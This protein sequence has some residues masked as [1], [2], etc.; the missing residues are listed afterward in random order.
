MGKRSELWGMTVDVSSEP[1]AEPEAAIVIRNKR[2]FLLQT[3]DEFLKQNDP[4]FE[5]SLTPIYFLQINALHT[6]KP[7]I[8]LLPFRF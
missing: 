2:R 4:L 8:I 7:E 6:D 5:L 3:D 1:L